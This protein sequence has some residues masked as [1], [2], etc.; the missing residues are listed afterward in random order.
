MNLP[1]DKVKWTEDPIVLST[2]FKIRLDQ[3][4]EVN[5]KSFDELKQNSTSFT[6]IPETALSFERKRSEAVI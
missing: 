6:R 1:K 4:V 3:L 5:S 2:S